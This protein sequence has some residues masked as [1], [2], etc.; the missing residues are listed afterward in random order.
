MISLRFTA[1]GIYIMNS[2]ANVCLF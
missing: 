1:Y 2:G